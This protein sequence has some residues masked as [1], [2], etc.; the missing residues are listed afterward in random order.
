MYVGTYQKGLSAAQDPSAPDR[1]ED[2]A[3]RQEAHRQRRARLQRGDRK[4][5]FKLNPFR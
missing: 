1:E 3:G 4:A 5:F 2:H